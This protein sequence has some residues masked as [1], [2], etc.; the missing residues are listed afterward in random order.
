MKTYIRLS[1]NQNKRSVS[2]I[3]HCGWPNI[4]IEDEINRIISNNMT[5]QHAGNN[6]VQLVKLNSTI[7]HLQIK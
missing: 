2:F 1:V 5:K 3:H 6:L 7:T 4:R